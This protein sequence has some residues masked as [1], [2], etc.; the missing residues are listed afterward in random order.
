MVELEVAGMEHHAQRRFDR[1]RRRVGDAVRYMNE[2]RR[3]LPQLHS[4]A[5]VDHPQVG[6]LDQLVLLELDR[7]QT[8]RK[9]RAV[10]RRQLPALQS[11]PREHVRQPPGVVF[12][13]MRDQ[14]PAQLFDPILDIT[15]VG[16]HQIDAE[17]LLIGEH[18]ARVHDDHVLGQ[19]K[20]HHVLAYLPEASQRNDLKAL[21]H[22]YWNRRICSASG[23]RATGAKAS[24]TF[25]SAF[26]SFRKSS[27]ITFRRFP[28]WSA[29]AGWYM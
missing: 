11:K 1:E 24:L 16:D 13:T 18:E 26:E 28:A 10:D 15:D 25:P 4:L 19:L 21:R 12:V 22:R 8:V 5:S 14:D 23:C 2:L 9:L 7:N 6:A 20:N 17:H 27:S 29:A 3:E